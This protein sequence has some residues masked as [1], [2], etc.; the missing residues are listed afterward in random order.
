M[1]A[2]RMKNKILQTLY[3]PGKPKASDFGV[4]FKDIEAMEKALDA[5]VKEIAGKKKD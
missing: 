4:A 1:A 5:A 3:K 2:S